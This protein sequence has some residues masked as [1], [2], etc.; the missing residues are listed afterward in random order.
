MK[1]MILSFHLSF[2]NKI[3]KMSVQEQKILLFEA[4]VLNSSLF[5]PLYAVSLH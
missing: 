3:N 4:V 1:L 5:L 2:L